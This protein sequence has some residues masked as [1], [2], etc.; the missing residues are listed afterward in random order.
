MHHEAG[1]RCSF[2]CVSGDDR[3]IDV[4][5]GVPLGGVDGGLDC[6]LPEGSEDT[7]RCIYHTSVSDETLSCGLTEDWIKDDFTTTLIIGGLA[8]VLA[9]SAFLVP[10]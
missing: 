9:V 6:I 2:K 5:C 10:L 7:D 4:S 8:S 3:H 1:G